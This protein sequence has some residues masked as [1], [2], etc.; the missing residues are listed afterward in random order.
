MTTRKQQV[1]ALLEAASSGASDAISVISA[2]GYIQHNLAVPDGLSGFTQML[3][4]L[5]KDSVRVDIVRI[6]EDGDFVVAHCN[7]EFF[8]SK[9]GFDIYRF[10]SGK[11]VEHWDNLQEVAGPNPSGHTMTDGQTAISDLDKTEANKALVKAYV[12]DILV[13]GRTEKFAGYFEGDSY[14]QHNPQIGDGLSELGKAFD[15]M[16]KNGLAIKYDTVHRVLGQ[17]NFVL[18]MSE[19]TFAGR[20]TAFYDLFRVEN[21][22]IAEHWDV[23]EAIR[24][25]SEWK[26]QNGKF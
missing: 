14:I 20:S 17:G 11:I 13:N 10:E 15:S 26:N 19:G 9:V 8:G 7:Y 18:T 3:A 22:K 6:F 4:A 25:K 1:I 21:G 2:D 24:A 5:P 23:I 12:D 16:A